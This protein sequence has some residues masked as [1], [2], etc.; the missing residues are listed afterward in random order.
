[1]PANARNGAIQ[2]LLFETKR[3]RKSENHS[4]KLLVTN[5]LIDNIGTNVMHV[6]LCCQ[7]DGVINFYIFAVCMLFRESGFRYN[8]QSEHVLCFSTILSRTLGFSHLQDRGHK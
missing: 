7:I 5:M 6:V 4:A 3:K 2:M 1:M 8:C